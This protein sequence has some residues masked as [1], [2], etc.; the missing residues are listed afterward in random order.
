MATQVLSAFPSLFQLLQSYAT[1]EEQT[2]SATDSVQLPTK[3][4]SVR[5][6]KLL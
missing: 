2:K 6:N 3:Q 5:Q 1:V 4:L